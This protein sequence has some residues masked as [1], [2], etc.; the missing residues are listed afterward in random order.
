MEYDLNYNVSMVEATPRAEVNGLGNELM[1]VDLGQR[2][3]EGITN[4]V[5]VS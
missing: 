2:G 4:H 3:N 5:L 1:Q